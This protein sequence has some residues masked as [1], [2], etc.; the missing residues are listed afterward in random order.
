MVLVAGDQAAACHLCHCWGLASQGQGG[1]SV[2]ETWSSRGAF[3]HLPC[4][5]QHPPCPC[6]LPPAGQ[7]CPA[8]R[9]AQPDHVRCWDKV[10]GGSHLELGGGASWRGCG[11][12]VDCMP[13]QQGGGLTSSPQPAHVFQACQGWPG[14]PAGLAQS[15]SLLC[16]GAE[17]WGRRELV[18]PGPAPCV[19][20]CAAGPVPAI[21]VQAPSAMPGVPLTA[22][23]HPP[24]H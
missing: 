20:L 7:S 16:T 22:S 21:D 8:L 23:S 5:Q 3:L 18:C 10:G 9:Q 6:P 11:R 15:C 17:L 14:A 24:H 1:G 19:T 2:A 12:G 4:L 13:P